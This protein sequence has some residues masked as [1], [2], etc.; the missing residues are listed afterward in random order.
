MLSLAIPIACAD[1]CFMQRVTEDGLEELWK[2][3][4]QLVYEKI[5]LVFIFSNDLYFGTEHL[6]DGFETLASMM[7]LLFKLSLCGCITCI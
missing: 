5:A 1:R 7:P 3:G 4:H 6:E 2:H